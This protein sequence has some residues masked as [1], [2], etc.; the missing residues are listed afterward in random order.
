MEYFAYG[1]DMNR[2]RMSELCPEAKP[3]YVARI[4]HHTL[5][6]TGRS[7]E[8][9]GGVA[10]IHLAVGRELWGGVYEF[11]ESCRGMIEEWGRRD[12]YV[13]CWTWVHRESGDRVKAA[14]LVKVRDLDQTTPAPEYLKDLREAWEQW[15]LDPDELLRARSTETGD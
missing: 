6:F 4:P 12:G 13:W 9:R 5:G 1:S 2:Q 14:T 11:P 15:G 7:R 8:T 3:L 10:T